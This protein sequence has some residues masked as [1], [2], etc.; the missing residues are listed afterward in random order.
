MSKTTELIKA[1]LFVT[2][3][4]GILRTIIIYLVLIILPAVILMRPIV[5]TK[6]FLD[7]LVICIAASALRIYVISPILITL[8]YFYSFLVSANTLNFGYLSYNWEVYTFQ[9]SFF[10]DMSP[11]VFVL[12]ATIVIPMSISAFYSYYIT[13][14]TGN[15][16]RPPVPLTGATIRDIILEILR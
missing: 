5:I 4:E 7:I 13:Q 6:T 16:R 15:I 12:F 14:A 1:Y 2:L 9:I 11:L 10:L 3:I 8:A